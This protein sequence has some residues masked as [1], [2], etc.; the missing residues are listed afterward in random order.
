MYHNAKIYE[1]DMLHT[2][3]KMHCQVAKNAKKT[4][5]KP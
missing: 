5:Q 1:N 3:P 4:N 2:N